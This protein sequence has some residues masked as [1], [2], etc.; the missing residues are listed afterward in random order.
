MKKKNIQGWTD[1]EMS[2][3]KITELDK[4]MSND[5]SLSLALEIQAANNLLGNLNVLAAMK[6]SEALTNA[7]VYVTLLLEELKSIKS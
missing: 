5:F 4:E 7:R 3:N 2:D 6:S 1:K